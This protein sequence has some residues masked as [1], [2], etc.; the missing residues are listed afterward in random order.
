MELANRLEL[1]ETQVKTWFQNRR[2]KCKK[3]QQAEQP[4]GAEEEKDKEE[5][6][7]EEEEELVIDEDGDVEE[8]KERWVKRPKLDSL[9]S[10]A[11]SPLTPLNDESVLTT[12]SSSAS[13]TTPS[14]RYT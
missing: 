1:S 6:E 13:C 11:S 8:E 10:Q 3:Q 5:E 4:E 9:S 14:N 12:G 2:M 7:E